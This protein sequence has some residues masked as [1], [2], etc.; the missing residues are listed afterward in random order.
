MNL[1]CPFRCCEETCYI[2]Q[3]SLESYAVEHSAKLWYDIML[4]LFYQGR[5]RIMSILNNHISIVGGLIVCICP[6]KTEG[7]GPMSFLTSPPAG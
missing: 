3:S 6:N 5:V 1:S 4:T 7:E 2:Q